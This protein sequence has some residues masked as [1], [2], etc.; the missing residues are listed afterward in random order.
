MT[1]MNF[2]YL[3]GNITVYN[4]T[5]GNQ[6]IGRNLFEFLFLFILD[7]VLLWQTL[8]YDTFTTYQSKFFI[9]FGG[10]VEIPNWLSCGVMMCIFS[11]LFGWLYALWNGIELYN[12]NRHLVEDRL[13]SLS[14]RNLYSNALSL[15]VRERND[16]QKTYN[17]LYDEKKMLDDI[18]K[19]QKEII[20]ALNYKMNV[21]EVIYNN[22]NAF[23]IT[24]RVSTRESGRM[25][26]YTTIPGY[27]QMRSLAEIRRVFTNT[28]RPISPQYTTKNK[29]P[30]RPKSA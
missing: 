13:V 8:L 4:Q 29:R 3:W 7:N 17:T 11:I 26:K 2:Q 14:K 5:G 30:K 24:V 20:A 15:M 21:A 10:S 9:F 18:L 6:C 1:M 28:K 27:T 22:G 19:N 12:K 25:D 16:I 23:D